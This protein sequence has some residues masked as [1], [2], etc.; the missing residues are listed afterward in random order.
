MYFR[1]WKFSVL[2]STR[3]TS[4]NK[5]LLGRTSV[6]NLLNN[7]LQER[8]FFICPLICYF[9]FGWWV[10]FCCHWTSP[11]DDF[12]RH[13]GIEMCKVNQFYSICCLDC[14][15]HKACISLGIL[16]LLWFNWFKLSSVCR[17]R[18][19]VTTSIILRSQHVFELIDDLLLVAN[20][21]CQV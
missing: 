20:V 4:E 19:F 6:F 18:N 13:N 10:H 14:F 11:K 5:Y 7:F 9:S 3:D 16:Y 8:H 12:I 2:S 1:I 15:H 21:F 17:S